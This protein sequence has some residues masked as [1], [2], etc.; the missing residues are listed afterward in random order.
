MICIKHLYVHFD[1]Y[2]IVNTDIIFVIIVRLVLFY[3]TYR[4]KKNM[5]NFFYI[6]I[7]KIYYY[8]NLFY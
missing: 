6:K 4:I 7:Q 5:K 1:N 8:I 3:F 2:I